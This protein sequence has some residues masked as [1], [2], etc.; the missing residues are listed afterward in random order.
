MFPL[1]AIVYIECL[2]KFPLF[3]KR[4]TWIRCPSLLAGQVRW[5]SRCSLF[6]ATCTGWTTGSSS[7]SGHFAKSCEHLDLR[8]RSDRFFG[9]PDWVEQI[10]CPPDSWSLGAIRLSKAEIIKCLKSRTLFIHLLTPA[11]SVYFTVAVNLQFSWR[12]SRDTKKTQSLPLQ[13]K[14]CIRWTKLAQGRSAVIFP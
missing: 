8:T 4:L 3:S 11:T 9:F 6:A 12:T 1:K 5:I 7:I 14:D 13:C 2:I 10:P